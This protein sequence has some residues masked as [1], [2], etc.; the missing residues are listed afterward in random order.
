M[1]SACSNCASRSD[2]E[3]RPLRLGREAAVVVELVQEVFVGLQP[4]RSPAQTGDLAHDTGEA[5][6]RGHRVADPLQ[7]LEPRVVLFCVQCK[8]AR[9][10]ISSQNLKGKHSSRVYVVSPRRRQNRACARHV[11][12]KNWQQLEAV[13][14]NSGDSDRP[15][16]RHHQTTGRKIGVSLAFATTASFGRQ[17]SRQRTRC[18]TGSRKGGT[19]K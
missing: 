10:G 5:L 2:A 11:E 15:H 6:S 3:K 4:A 14:K 9:H 13:R 16:N 17:A 18:T 1:L 19:R 8:R 7:I 12:P